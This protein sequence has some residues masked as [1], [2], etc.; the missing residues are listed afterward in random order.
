MSRRSAEDLQR[1]EAEGPSAS[2]ERR[3]GRALLNEHA[4]RIVIG[5][6]M[7]SIAPDRARAQSRTPPGTPSL[8]Y[9]EASGCAGLFMYT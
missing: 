7:V 2:E 8:R 6:L 3:E 9:K 1:A 4:A 5:L